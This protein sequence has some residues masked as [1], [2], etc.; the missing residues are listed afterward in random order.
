MSRKRPIHRLL[1]TSR[2][3]PTHS[4]SLTQPPTI[5]TKRKRT[6]PDEIWKIW[7]PKLTAEERQAI[8]R[9]IEELDGEAQ[10]E[11]TEEMRAAPGRSGSRLMQGQRAIR[12][13]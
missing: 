13:D 5:K 7:L 4:R 8:Y 2:K 10:F 12:G 3:R 1:H 11:A 9:K 6:R